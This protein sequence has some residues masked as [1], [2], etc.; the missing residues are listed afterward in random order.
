MDAGSCSLAA[1]AN[2]VACCFASL[3]GN[4][5]YLV[6]SQLEGNCDIN[7]V[8]DHPHH[9]AHKGHEEQREPDDADEEEDDEASHA[10]FDNLLLFLTLG[11]WVFLQGG[12]RG[13]VLAPEVFCR[14]PPFKLC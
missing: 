13:S 2:W 4:S 9:R 11:L 10:V 7:G 12:G 5:S 8:V 14:K 6:A 3:Q 1:S